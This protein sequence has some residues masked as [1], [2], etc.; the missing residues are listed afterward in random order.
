VWGE[1]FIPDR[2][3]L[4]GLL[5]AVATPWLVWGILFYR[6]WRNSNDPVTRAVAWLLRGSVLELLIAVPAHVMV[7]RRHEC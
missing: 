3:S 7:R 5:G 4:V 1:K 6:L 2:T